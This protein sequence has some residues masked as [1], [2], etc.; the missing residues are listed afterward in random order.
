MI[1]A[2]IGGT[3]YYVY[4]VEVKYSICRN[5]G[6]AVFYIDP[7]L[8]S[9]IL[10]FEEVTLSCDGTTIFKGYIE[11][12]N[13]GDFPFNLE[14]Q[15][16]S[17]VLKLERSWF[18]T[19]YISYG[20]SVS[21][22]VDVFM[23]LGSVASYSYIGDD[24]PVYAG[25]SWQFQTCLEALKNVTQITDC[26]LYP[27][28]EGN[29]I[30]APLA[31]SGLDYTITLYEKVVQEYI[32]DS[33]RNRVIVWGQDVQ[34]EAIGSIAYVNEIRT[35]ALSTGLIETVAEASRVANRMLATYQLPQNIRTFTI[36]GTPGLSLNDYVSTPLGDGAITSLAHRYNG[37]K[38]VT[39]V[40]IGEI[41][42]AFF[43]LSKRTVPMYLSGIDAGV[44]KSVNYGTNWSN[45][46]GTTLYGVTVKAIHSDETYLWAITSNN[47]YRSL[48]KAGDWTLCSIP[49][50]L[51]YS[52]SG[53][54]YT[55]NKSDLELYD[56]I[57]DNGKVFVVAQDTVYKRIIVL[58]A[59]NN[60]SFN[61]YYSV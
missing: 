36:D 46:S 33:I 44:W 28:R 60:Y 27:D 7:N 55:I 16:S 29:I 58:Y 45:I 30:V 2:L 49:N 6:T 17:E 21:Y 57:S 8:K 59:T 24:Y 31:T 22:W 23:N 35:I 11:L 12:V 32:T 37:E 14:I 1:N 47:I 54:E 19:E 26:Q 20:E 4:D 52:Y 15:A 41:C 25:H 34:A 13:F 43:G 53:D 18:N 56:I 5:S 3:T 50:T 38:Y 39:D 9:Q 10:P 42:P 48:N 61:K 51:T 40:T